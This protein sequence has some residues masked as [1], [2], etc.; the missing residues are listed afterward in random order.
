MGGGRLHGDGCLRISYFKDLVLDN[1]T[2]IAFEHQFIAVFHTEVWQQSIPP[3]PES[4]GQMRGGS[5]Y[6]EYRF[7]CKYVNKFTS[8]RI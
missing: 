8:K 1:T 7:D 3:A 4:R 6:N 2:S 5:D